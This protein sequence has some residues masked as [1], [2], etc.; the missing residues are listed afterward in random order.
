LQKAYR[1]YQGQ[2]VLFLGAFVLSK[3]QDIG[4]FARR[5]HLT[6]PVG[7]DTGI[8]VALGAVKGIPETI[9]IGRDGRIVRRHNGLID[10]ATLTAGIKELLRDDQP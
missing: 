4:K 3:E 10:Y 1:A 5:H 6:F 2:G 8:G 9:F 7:R